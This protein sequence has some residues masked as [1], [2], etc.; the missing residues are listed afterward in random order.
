MLNRFCW[1]SKPDPRALFGTIKKYNLIL[2]NHPEILETK[3]SPT[4]T[5]LKITFVC[6]FEEIEFNPNAKSSMQ[7]SPCTAVMQN[8]HT[9]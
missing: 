8:V 5:N 7:V 1:L 2:R 4:L 6:L 9:S 3:I